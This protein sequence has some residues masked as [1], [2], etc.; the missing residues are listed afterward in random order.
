MWLLYDNQIVNNS[1]RGSVTD[2]NHSS[3]SIPYRYSY[4]AMNIIP[5]QLD[6]ETGSFIEKS[7][8]LTSTGLPTCDYSLLKLQS[9]TVYFLLGCLVT[10][11]YRSQDLR[12]C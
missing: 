11:G 2:I 6:L 8:F 7:C 5:R 10:Y 4:E 12:Q 3:P 1:V 9:D